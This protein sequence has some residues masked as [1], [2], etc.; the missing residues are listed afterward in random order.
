[1]NENDANVPMRMHRRETR[2]GCDASPPSSLTVRR[3][4]A[5]VCA[6]LLQTRRT[7]VRR[8]AGAEATRRTARALTVAAARLWMTP[9]AA[10]K[11]AQMRGSSNNSQPPI[12]ADEPIRMLHLSTLHTRTRVHRHATD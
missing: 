3:R 11:E 6:Q 5:V 10:H 2:N 8:E 9:T 4:C 12:L 1:M 7:K